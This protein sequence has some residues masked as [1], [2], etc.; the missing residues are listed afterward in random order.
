MSKKPTI[1]IQDPKDLV[2]VFTKHFSWLFGLVI[3]A[4]LIGFITM[5]FMVAGLVVETWRFNTQVYDKLQITKSES[6]ATET[7][8]EQDIQNSLD[9]IKKWFKIK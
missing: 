5:L 3:G 7:A 4:M 6:I 8:K 1:Q 2:E 9:S